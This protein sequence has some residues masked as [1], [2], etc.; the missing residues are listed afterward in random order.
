M[1]KARKKLKEEDKKP[2]LITGVKERFATS[3]IPDTTELERK[4]AESNR[5]VDKL[6]QERKSLLKKKILILSE[7]SKKVRHEIPDEHNAYK[8]YTEYSVNSPQ[9]FMR[10]TFAEIATQELGHMEKLQRM[11]R[12]IEQEIKQ[13]ER[14]LSET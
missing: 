11:E 9:P 5:E 12:E 7:F 3:L 14:E 13:A 6:K 10:D 1:S 4:A 8:M 2:T